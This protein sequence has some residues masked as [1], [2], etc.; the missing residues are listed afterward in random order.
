MFQPYE[1]IV[2]KIISEQEKIIGPIAV[3]QAKQVPGVIIDWSKH[4][5]KVES[6]DKKRT[7]EEVV[8]KYKDLFGKVAVEVCKEALSGMEIPKDELPDELQ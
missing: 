1:K 2:E 6:S 8:D 3:E 5:V 7:L 4:E